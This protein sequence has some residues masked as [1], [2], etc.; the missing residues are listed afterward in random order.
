MV[1]VA[2]AVGPLVCDHSWSLGV[3]INCAV[4]HALACGMP[5]APSARLT[6]H[7]ASV[8][9]GEIQANIGALE[10]CLGNKG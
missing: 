3:R 10:M 8:K 5:Y 2:A 6:V 4:T 1:V 9:Y 7:V